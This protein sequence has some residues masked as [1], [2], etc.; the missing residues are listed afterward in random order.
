MVTVTHEETCS[1]TCHAWMSNCSLY[2]IYLLPLW[3][4]SNASS[5]CVVSLFISGFPQHSA[6]SPKFF[7]MAAKCCM[8]APTPNFIWIPRLPSAQGSPFFCLNMSSLLPLQF[9]SVAQ[10]CLTLCDPMDCSIPGFPVHHHLPD[11]M[12]THVH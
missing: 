9:S 11:L 10:L 3:V 5:S 1:G 6:S 7:P 8:P 2:I 4:K 12:Q